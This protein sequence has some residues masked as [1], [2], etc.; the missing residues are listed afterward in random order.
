M[1]PNAQS[2][3][4]CHV[5]KTSYAA[6]M[7][8]LYIKKAS[9][10]E[11]GKDSLSGKLRDELTGKRHDAPLGRGDRADGI[12]VGAPKVR[13]RRIPEVPPATFDGRLPFNTGNWKVIT[14]L[15]L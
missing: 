13:N 8:T 10:C 7:R 4:R 12:V 11:N 14:P 6:T 1:F 2:P 15:R 3:Q 9:A 5:E